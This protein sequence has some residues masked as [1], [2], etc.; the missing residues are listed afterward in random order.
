MRIESR[1][2][3]R[4]RRF[5]EAMFRIVHAQ[6]EAG[7]QPFVQRGDIGKI[8][9]LHHV[10]IFQWVKWKLVRVILLPSGR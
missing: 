6:A 9:L 10:V 2:H 7:L 5:A 3:R 8:D 1:H 4:Q